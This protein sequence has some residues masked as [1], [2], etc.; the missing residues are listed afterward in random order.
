[1]P[2]TAIY[3]LPYQ[4]L[5]DPPNGPTLGQNLAQAIEALLQSSTLT[6][7]GGLTL[8]GSGNLV[9]PGTITVGGSPLVTSKGYVG[10][11]NNTT[12]P[13]STSSLNGAEALCAS[14]TFTSAGTS[15]RYKFQWEGVHQGSVSALIGRLRLRIQSG[16]SVTSGGGTQLRIRTIVSTAGE[17]KPFVLSATAT[18]LAAGTW[19]FGGTLQLVGST[20]GTY[21]VNASSTDD[22]YARVDRTA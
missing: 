3:G 14:V 17:G 7:G 2:S 20:A 12:T 22:E 19:T 16:A 18:G 5:T 10:E 15:A 9:V 1:M 4:A 11:L 8:G 21:T 13:H 6:L